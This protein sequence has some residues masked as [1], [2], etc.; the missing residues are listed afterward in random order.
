VDSQ[1]VVGAAAA[2]AAGDLAAHDRLVAEA[3]CRVA[4]SADVV[5][6]A[7]ASMASAAGAADVAVAVLTSPASGADAV[8]AAAAAR[9]ACPNRVVGDG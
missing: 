1:V 2:R 8:V 7:Q 6:L 3:V 5:V 4:G 9:T